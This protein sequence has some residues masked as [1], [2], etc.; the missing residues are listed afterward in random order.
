MCSD[1]K[2]TVKTT[3]CVSERLFVAV[4]ELGRGL[5]LVA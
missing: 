4:Q 2:L 1:A 5:A 3:A